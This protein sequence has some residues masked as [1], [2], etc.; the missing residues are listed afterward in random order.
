MA[1]TTLPLSKGTYAAGLSWEAYLEAMKKHRELSAELYREAK[2]TDSERRELSDFVKRRGGALSIS[3]MTEDWCGDS[4][5]NLPIVKRLS[6][7]AD[8]V[9]F[10]VFFGSRNP[11]LKAG[12]EAAGIDHIPV[13]SLFDA[14]FREIG[15]WVE[16]PKAAKVK[17]EGWE[18]AHP[19]L[20]RLRASKDV[21][22]KEALRALYDG[23][24]VEMSGWY[25]GGLW[26]ETVRELLETLKEAPL[27]R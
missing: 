7:A 17:V 5:N 24:V 4:A 14:D 26:R 16:R 13:V 15:R 6:E 8:G 18:A 21:A 3:V 1:T 12:Y 20:S 10:R 19:E 23:L 22:D 27:L 9:A 2:I 11:E 25:R